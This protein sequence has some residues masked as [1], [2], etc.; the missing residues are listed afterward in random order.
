M[1]KKLVIVE[2]PTKARTISRFLGNNFVVESSYGHIRDLPLSKLGVDVEHDFSPQYLIPAKAR[3]VVKRLRA[4]AK[5]AHTIIL[6]TDED[7]EGEAIA[8]HL[9][10]A[11]GLEDKP[12]DNIVRI[13]FHE[14]TERAIR[15]AL[16]HPRDLDLKR[17]NAQQARRIL[18]RLVG[19]KLSP[20]LWKKVYRGLSAG[21]VQSVALRLIVERE[22]EIKKFIPEEYWTIEALLAKK[23]REESSPQSLRATLMSIDGKTLDKFGI[24][25]SADAEIVKNDLENAS[26]TVE[27]VEKKAMVKNPLPPHTTST[28]QQDAF[29]KLGFSAKQ[30]MILAQQLYEGIELGEGPTGL[31]TY[32]RTDSLTLSEESLTHA[33]NFIKKE[34]GEPYALPSPR[35]FKTTAKG[36]Q[37]AHEAI[38]PT[39]PARTPES[40]KHFLERRQ[41]RLYELIWRRFI[42]TQ[43]SAAIFDNTGVNIN[44]TP[45]KT[46]PINTRY[47]FRATGQMMK[48]DGFLKAYPVK[49][50]EVDIPEL[51][52]HEKLALEELAALQHFTEPPP[53]FTEAS[54][55][56]IMEKYGIGRPS[57]YAPTLSTI[58]DRKYVEKDERRRLVPTEIGFVVCDLLVEHFPEI[59]DI[60]FTAKMEEEL[61][62]I[63]E[64]KREWQPV[65]KEFYTPFAQHLEEKYKEVKKHEIEET[66]EEL[67]E[68]CG[69]P[70][71]VKLGRFGKFLACSGF[72]ECKTT[73]TLKQAPQTIGMKCPKCA[74][75]DIIIKHTKKRRMFYGC[76]RY[77]ECDYASWADPRNAQKEKEDLNQED[78]GQ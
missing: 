53:R 37:E 6:A 13:V 50:A 10:F 44:A 65:I 74:T 14:I 40:I 57:T 35:R 54:L 75:G 4:E 30:T 60:Q 48:F 22:R 39:D 20:F 70:M 12:G 76:S 61:D 11:L 33:Q 58:Q 24:T 45:Q 8:W 51:K 64:G 25:Q 69:R 71:V 15:D 26:W 18:D 9:L 7:R 52:P 49:F 28:L 42:A 31:I 62:E 59:V 41:F 32:M 27:E 55:I 17:V 23:Q 29:R 68:K 19:Y 47:L 16:S 21:R 63:A 78:Q 56:K 1:E 34:F 67:C 38:R 46:N 36:A 2:S 3:P 73:K 77:P 72:P 43:M 5:K 66:T